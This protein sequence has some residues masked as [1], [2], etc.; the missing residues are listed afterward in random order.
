MTRALITGSADGLG[1]AAAESLLDDGHEVIVHARSVERLTAVGDLISRGAASVVGDLADFR[2]VR[3]L[4]DRG[5]ELGAVDAVIHN[6]G[7]LDGPSLLPVN[8]VA[9]YLLSASIAGPRRHIYLSSG[10]HRG[11]RADVAAAD[12]SGAKKTLSYSDSKLLVTVLMAAVARRRPE[13]IAHAVDP[14]WVPTK[15]GGASAPDDLFLGHVTQTWLA[16][17][18][19]A[20]V[21]ASGRYWH[22]QRVQSA[23]PAVHDEQFQDELLAALAE[24]T[25]VVLE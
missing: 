11:G 24:H 2:A 20:D 21:L 25:G 8:V 16:T 5:N 12:W 15:M 22:H 17:S 6:A 18:S 19:D 1:R 4:A 10:M 9:P 13:I 7:V 14:G 23:H 3:A